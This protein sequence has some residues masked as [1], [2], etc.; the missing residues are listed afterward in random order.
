MLRV[1]VIGVCT[2]ALAAADSPVGVIDQIGVTRGVNGHI[3]GFGGS[4][5]FFSHRLRQ[6][7]EGWHKP[8]H[9]GIGI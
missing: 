2:A 6:S 9:A 8:E 7:M 1:V 3:T 4:A 5:S